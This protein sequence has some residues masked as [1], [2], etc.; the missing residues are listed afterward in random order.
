MSRVF[1]RRRHN[2]GKPRSRGHTLASFEDTVENK[3]VVDCKYCSQPI[4]WVTS[5]KGK[6][7]PVNFYG[8]YSHAGN[9]IIIKNDFHKCPNKPKGPQ[10]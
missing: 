7:Y 1:I 8:E 6:R 5:P 4:A 9:P 2:Q 10:K 3:D